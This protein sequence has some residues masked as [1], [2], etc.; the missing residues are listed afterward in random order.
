MT[1]TTNQAAQT[2]ILA[3]LEDHPSFL[4]TIKQKFTLVAPIPIVDE[5]TEH[6]I[7]ESLAEYQAGKGTVVSSPK[8]LL[9]F[10][11]SIKQ[12]HGI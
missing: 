5:E 11:D 2:F 7:G 12:E 9:G 8:E 6:R 1:I 3:Y 4:E 10:L